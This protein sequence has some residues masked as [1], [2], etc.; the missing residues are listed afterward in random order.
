MRF[1]KA[2]LTN[3]N[4]W[5]FAASNEYIKEYVNNT[6]DFRRACDDEQSTIDE[7]WHDL[8][9]LGPAATPARLAEVTYYTFGGGCDNAIL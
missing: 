6:L 1:I 7:F 8:P 2:K 3:L 4:F 5:S 9:T